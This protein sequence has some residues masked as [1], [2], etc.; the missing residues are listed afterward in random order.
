VG[1]TVESD[2]FGKAVSGKTTP[3]DETFPD[4]LQAARAIINGLG[5]EYAVTGPDDVQ[6]HVAALVTGPDAKNLKDAGF[7]IPVAPLCDSILA[8]GFDCSILKARATIEE[9]LSLK[10]T[11]TLP[12]P[13]YTRVAIGGFES[14]T[15]IVVK[16]LDGISDLFDFEA[17]GQIMVRYTP[18]TQ[19]GAIGG[20]QS[21]LPVVL[22]GD[23]AFSSTPLTGSANEFKVWAEYNLETGGG[24]VGGFGAGVDVE[25]TIP[26]SKM[27]GL[28]SK[29]PPRGRECAYNTLKDKI[30]LKLPNTDGFYNRTYQGGLPVSCRFSLSFPPPPQIIA[31]APSE[32]PDPGG[33]A[34]MGGD[35]EPVPAGL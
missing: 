20:T 15:T 22:Q 26:I 28:G 2:L 27:P 1:E 18:G 23:T 25:V 24:N 21:P 19:T 11:F 10:L 9:D 14:S 32:N 3:F 8:Y 35:G 33:L 16:D 12:H 29:C 4:D 7:G 5:L 17:A 6:R 30:Q 34:G 31:E 13:V